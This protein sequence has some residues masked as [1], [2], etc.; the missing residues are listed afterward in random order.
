ME[1]TYFNAYY[2]LLIINYICLFFLDQCYSGDQTV[3]TFD[4]F[5]KSSTC[6]TGGFKLCTPN[7]DQL[8]IGQCSSIYVYKFKGMSGKGHITQGNFC[9]NLQCNFLTWIHIY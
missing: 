2:V 9:C 4:R 8:C 5:G 6:I 7:P 3:K 1:S